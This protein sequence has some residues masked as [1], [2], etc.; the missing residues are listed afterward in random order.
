MLL[1]YAGIMPQRID[2]VTYFKRCELERLRVTN[3][4]FGYAALV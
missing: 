2:L 1:D 3:A 4:I